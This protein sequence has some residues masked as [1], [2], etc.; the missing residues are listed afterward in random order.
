MTL[1]VIGP[2]TRDLIIKNDTK[3]SKIGGAS[4][5]QAFV[6]EEFYP[7]YLCI[8]TGKE[9]SLINEFPNMDMVKFIKKD[10]THYFINDYPDSDDTD[11]RIQSSNFAN[12][13]ISKSDL[14]DILPVNI[15]AFVINPLNLY[16]FPKETISYL[17]TFDVPIYMSIQGFLRHP[18]EKIGDNYSIKLKLTPEIK[19][20]I[21]DIDG[22][23]LD[24][25]EASIL[26]EKEDCED[27]NIKEII[28][29]NGSKGSRVI[30]DKEYK[31]EAVKNDMII[32]AT[33]CGDTFMAAYISKKLTTKS[34]LKSANF[35]SKIA[36]DKLSFF[37]P[38]KRDI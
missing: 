3:E 9:S 18:S 12:I 36:S 26:F 19:E 10:N 4:F 7:D 5:F 24:E 37:G 17:K 20:I 8:V 35:A 15:D 23:F 34:I 28:I 29:T 13:P 21:R 33:G 32:D 22:L 2:L 11:I 30:S 14:D 25:N 16:D 31:I 6:F 1:V 38:F 27:F